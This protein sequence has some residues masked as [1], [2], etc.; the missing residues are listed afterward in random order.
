MPEFILDFIRSR[1]RM[2][3]LFPQGFSVL[4]TQSVERLLHRI[5][6]HPEFLAD[7]SLGKMSRLVYQ[8]QLQIIE[9]L[10]S[11]RA[12]I[13]RL[14]SA[15]DLIKHRARPLPFVNLIG[16]QSFERFELKTLLL[17]NFIERDGLVTPTALRRPRFVSLVRQEVLERSEEI[18]TQSP[19]LPPRGIEISTFQ[20]AG[21]KFLG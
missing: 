17:D 19:F 18:G 10:S 3:K 20:P 8:E 9:Q 16:R 1:D 4:Q 7:F 6:G 12:A 21:E 5:L 14:E 2:G 13:V 15:Q 11:P